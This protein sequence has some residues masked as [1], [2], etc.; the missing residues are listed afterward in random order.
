MI[1]RLSQDQLLARI[2]E[3][4]L[5]ITAISNEINEIQGE[6]FVIDTEVGNALW[7]QANDEF[8]ADGEHALRSLRYREGVL[9]LYRSKL[10]EIKAPK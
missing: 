6:Y 7:G 8:M 1:R 3:H 5:E 2:T 10:E 9:K 4:D